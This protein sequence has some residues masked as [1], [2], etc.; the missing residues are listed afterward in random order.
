M[1]VLDERACASFAVSTDKSSPPLY[2]CTAIPRLSEVH[3]ITV[4]QSTTYPKFCTGFPDPTISEVRFSPLLL[5]PGEWER[6]LA[7]LAS[8]GSAMSQLAET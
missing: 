8:T 6:H 7:S 4:E 3:S 2:L 1:L 5:A